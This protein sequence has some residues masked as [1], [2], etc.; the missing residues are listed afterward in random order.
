MDSGMGPLRAPLDKK[1][2]E[3]KRTQGRKY[4][5]QEG[6]AADLVETVLDQIPIAN[7]GHSL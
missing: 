2:R 4:V 1:K 3:R 7:T 6:T 5:H